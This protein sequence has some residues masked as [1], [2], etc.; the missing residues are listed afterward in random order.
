MQINIL[1]QQT[2][3]IRV[4]DI[5]VPNVI[6]T[7]KRQKE[8]NDDECDTIA[9]PFSISGYNFTAHSY[10]KPYGCTITNKESKEL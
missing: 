10:L 1:Q 9:K 2:P 5:Q 3:G 7:C 4:R 6:F 8:E